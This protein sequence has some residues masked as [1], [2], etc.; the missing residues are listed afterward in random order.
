[1]ASRRRRLA[2]DAVV[3]GRRED[4]VVGAGREDAERAALRLDGVLR[5]TRQQ[6]I[7]AAFG[8]HADRTRADG[9]TPH[10]RRA[11]AAHP[12]TTEGLTGDADRSAA[13]DAEP[14]AFDADASTHRHAL[15]TAAPRRAPAATRRAI[16]QRRGLGLGVVG[17]AH[18]R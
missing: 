6:S 5:A 8:P 18:A 4:A 16:G 9:L 1:D 15:R 14:L 13:V 12:V 11:L 2:V 17:R 3:R 10:A 7:R